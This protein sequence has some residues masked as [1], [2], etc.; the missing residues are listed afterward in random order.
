M[1]LKELAERLKTVSD[2]P[3]LDARLLMKYCPEQIDDML[4]RRLNYE[5]ISKIIG[6]RGFWK[7]DFVVNKDVLDPR[8]D[9]EKVIEAVLRYYPDQSR[10]Y[11]ILDI[12][13]G[14]GCLLFSLLDEYP[15]AKGVGIDCSDQ[16]LAVAERNRHSRSAELVKRDFMNP[17]WGKDLGQFD[18]VVSNPPY[19]PTKDIETLSPDVRNYDPIMAL[20]GGVDGLNAYRALASDIGPLLKPG[21]YLFLEIGIGQADDVRSLFLDVFRYIDTIRDFGGIKRVLVFQKPV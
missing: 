4:Q 21:S 18:I 13:T 20:D 3:L 12:G 14:S 17:D 2:T 19:I 7:S 6:S 9:S 11:R 8:P 1:T 15:M 10:P 5:P 16:A